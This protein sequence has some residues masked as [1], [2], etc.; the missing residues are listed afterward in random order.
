MIAIRHM[1]NMCLSLDH[2]ILDGLICG[3]FL[4]RV[5]ENIESFG[6]DTQLY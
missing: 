1:A 4:E 3:R 6:R 2:R 5:K